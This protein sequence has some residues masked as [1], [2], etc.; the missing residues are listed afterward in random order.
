MKCDK[1]AFTVI[2]LLDILRHKEICNL[3]CLIT[4]SI[5][6]NRPRLLATE[7][8]IISLGCARFGFIVGG[9][10]FKIPMYLKMLMNNNNVFY[11]FS[12]VDC[13]FMLDQMCK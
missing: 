13:S 3:I 7:V 9:P 2:E 4:S 5:A 8:F 11:Y 10:D 12:R 6:F 1:Y